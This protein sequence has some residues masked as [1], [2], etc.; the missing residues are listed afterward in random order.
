[1]NTRTRR[2]ALI[3]GAVVLTLVTAACGSDSDDTTTETTAAAAGE[4]TAAPPPLSP[5]TEAPAAEGATSDV[6]GDVF[7]SGSSTVEPISIKVG[8]L[9]GEQ[10]GGKVAVTVDGPGTGDGFKTFCAGETDI[11]DASR[12]IKDE[13]AATLRRCRHRV[14]RARGRDRRPDRRHQPGEHGNRVPR[15][16]GALRPA[17]P[18]VGRVRRSGPTP[19]RWP[20]SSVRRTPTSSPTPIWWSPARARSRAPTTRSSSSSSRRSPRSVRRTASSVPTTRRAATTT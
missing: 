6:E 10:T 11:S 17:R 7:V 15:R 13:E 2:R 12:K 9:I 18:G 20:P 8:E 5:A 16:Q 19:P 14:H 3:A 1:M 4:T